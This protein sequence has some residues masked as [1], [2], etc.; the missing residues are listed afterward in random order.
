M[1]THRCRARTG[2]LLDPSAEQR[3]RCVK[4]HGH[5]DNH[6]A[7]ANRTPIEWNEQQ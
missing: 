3:Y 6:R 4:E 7:Y 1:L 5:S 2:E